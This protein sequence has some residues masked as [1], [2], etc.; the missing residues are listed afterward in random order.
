MY[1]LLR[2]SVLLRSCLLARAPAP[3]RTHGRMRAYAWAHARP[4][5]PQIGNFSTLKPRLLDFSA[6]QLFFET[7]C[8]SGK[9]QQRPAAKLE[10]L[11][12]I[13]KLLEI[14]NTDC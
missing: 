8:A 2:A 6:A 14:E 13:R 7:R 1:V 9:N 4:R 3:A 5:G 11:A 10:H 12:R